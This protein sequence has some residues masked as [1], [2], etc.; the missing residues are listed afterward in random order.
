VILL[1]GWITFSL[2]WLSLIV[3]LNFNNR[4][5]TKVKIKIADSDK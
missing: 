3:A 1:P 4:G 2:A 5:G